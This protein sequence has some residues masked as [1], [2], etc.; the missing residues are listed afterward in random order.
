[1]IAVLTEAISLLPK[2][3]L[4]FRI[5]E[6]PPHPTIK[7][8]KQDEM[9]FCL[10]YHTIDWFYI[11]YRISSDWTV[12]G[13]LVWATMRS[14]DFLPTSRTWQILSNSTSPETVRQNHILRRQNLKRLEYICYSWLC[15]FCGGS[16]GTI[17][18]LQIYKGDNGV[19][20]ES[21]DRHY[22]QRWNDEDC[23]LDP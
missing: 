18:H 22:S 21:L 12:F 8:D 17:S 1:M 13:S 20:H 11:F 19:C 15:C 2:A 14:S 6:Y 23:G 5:L 10:S 16:R 9:F 7:R 3:V 4:L